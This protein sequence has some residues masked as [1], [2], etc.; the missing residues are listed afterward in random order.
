VSEPRIEFSGLKGRFFAWFL[1]SPLRHVLE[2]RMG[3]PESRLLE[4]LALEGDEVV[5]DA[6][7]GSGFHS[8]LVAERLRS[9]KVLAFDV[10]DEM[11]ARLRRN[12]SRRDLATK[13]DARLGDAL[14]LP[15]EDGCADRA[16]TVAVWHHMDDPPGACV[17]LTRVL[18][19]GGRLVAVDLEI[20]AHG[21]HGGHVGG[22]H[23]AFG[24]ADM[25][26]ILEEAGLRDRRVEKIGRWVIGSAIK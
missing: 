23:R 21:R 4:L 25:L 13:I 18:R 5:V 19:P 8:L 20:T 15:L 12:A 16:V 11:L 24:E 9:G 3:A 22:H 17:E 10:S 1:T 6:G 2:W 26:R 7:C 14:S